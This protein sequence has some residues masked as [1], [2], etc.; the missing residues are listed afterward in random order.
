VSTKSGEDQTDAVCP[1]MVLQ[2]F[3]GPVF[4][5]DVSS[6]KLTVAVPVTLRESRIWEEPRSW[7]AKQ[8]SL[9]ISA[10]GFVQDF[11][12]L[13]E[14]TALYKDLPIERVA[15]ILDAEIQRSGERVQMLGL[16][17][18]LKV[19]SQ[20]AAGIIMIVQMY[21]VLHLKQFRLLS[22]GIDQIAW[23]ALYSNSYARFL[24]LATGMILPAATC[25]YATI[26]HS[27]Y[28]NW[29]CTLISIVLAARSAPL[30]W[31]LPNQCRSP[32]SANADWPG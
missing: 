2:K 10:T 17:L 15:K 14:V 5:A 31:Q 28:F 21:F 8:Y 27:S 24:T 22:S 30:L 6:E 32:R 4:C 9:P 18:S 11:R 7:L 12:E 23:V 29:I 3:A 16:T 13:N 1:E 26:T 25:V 20:A 19:L